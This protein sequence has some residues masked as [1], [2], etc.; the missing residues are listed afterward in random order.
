MWQNQQIFVCYTD[1][2]TCNFVFHIIHL[3]TTVRIINCF[4]YTLELPEYLDAYL[5]VFLARSLFW[6]C[7]LTHWTII[8]HIWLDNCCCKRVVYKVSSNYV[9]LPPPHTHKIVLLLLIAG[10]GVLQPNQ[11]RYGCSR[12]F[13][14]SVLISFFLACRLKVKL[15]KFRSFWHLMFSNSVC[16]LSYLLTSERCCVLFFFL[17]VSCYFCT[18]VCTYTHTQ[19]CMHM[20][21]TRELVCSKIPCFSF[22]IDFVRQFLVTV[23][24]SLSCSVSPGNSR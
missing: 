14:S 4:K 6:W 22:E 10:T 17:Y 21:T 13:A 11:L 15:A 24:S 1:F 18:Y 5:D 2:H 20:N 9:S 3:L 19:K 23:T 8:Y 7:I 12:L 16:S